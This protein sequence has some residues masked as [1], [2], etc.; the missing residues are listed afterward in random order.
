VYPRRAFLLAAIA[1]LLAASPAQAHT[2][3]P[4]FIPVFDGTAPPAPAVRVI[5]TV[6]GAAPQLTVR[7]KGADELALSGIDGE[8]FVRIGPQGGFLNEASPTA[9]LSRDAGAKRPL[10]TPAP[11]SA[12]AAPPAPA[13]WKRIT[14]KP[15]LSWYE[16][17]AE[18]PGLQAPEGVRRAN[19]RTSIYRWSIEGRLG[20]APIQLFGHVDWVPRPFDASL[21]IFAGVVL[22]FLVALMPRPRPQRAARAGAVLAIL[23]IGAQGAMLASDARSGRGSA[24]ALA[25]VPAFAIAAYGAFLQWRQD[26]LGGAITATFG[27]WLLGFGTARLLGGGTH[28]WLRAG[29]FAHVLLGAA[30]A[31]AW[32][33]GRPRMGTK[34]SVESVAEP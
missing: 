14:R 7:V 21:L 25:L 30:L 31:G 19:R 17:R 22:V 3:G 15:E 12:P 1:T 26:R 27:L 34:A 4:Q 33:L 2:V 8:P 16:L 13:R 23:G 24:A 32:A 5:V 18:W 11:A 9:K 28:S 6:T 20:E 10:V 29:L